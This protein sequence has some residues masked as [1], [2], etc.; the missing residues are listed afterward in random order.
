MVD[1]SAQLNSFTQG[2]SF[3]ALDKNFSEVL[4]AAVDYRGDLLITL[5]DGTS[6]EGYVFNSSADRLDLFPRN[7]PRAVSVQIAE[8]DT[9]TFSGEDTANGKSYDDW[10]TKKEA[11]K[12]AIK[13][14][15]IEMV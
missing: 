14:Q 9:L 2:Q 13:A 10:L 12:A 3:K 7:S 5:K 11:D 15:P 1:S 4:R 6:V 8:V